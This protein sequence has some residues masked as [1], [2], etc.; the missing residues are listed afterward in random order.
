M[1]SP[2]PVGLKNAVPAIRSKDNRI[3]AAA[4]T[5]VDKRMSAEVANLNRLVT[6]QDQAADEIGHCL[7]RRQGHRKAANTEASQQWDKVYPQFLNTI[8]EDPRA[9]Q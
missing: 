9:K 2:P 7:L 4:R 8:D 6:E 1:G 3:R 5:G